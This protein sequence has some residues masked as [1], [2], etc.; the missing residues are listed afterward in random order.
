[1]DDQPEQATN[2][3]ER[4]TLLFPDVQLRVEM[5]AKEID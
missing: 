3:N 5:Q 1:M 4:S 2:I